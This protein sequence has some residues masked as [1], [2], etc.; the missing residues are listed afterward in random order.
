[1]ACMRAFYS[2]FVRNL[3]TF[4]DLFHLLENCVDSAPAVYVETHW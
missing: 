3:D 2:A 4:E 1:M